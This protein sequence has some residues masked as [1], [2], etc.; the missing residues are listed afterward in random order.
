MDR[1]DLHRRLPTILQIQADAWNRGDIEAFMDDYWKS[2]QLTFSS[3]GE[4]QRGWDATLQR[5][6]RRYPTPERMGRLTFSEIETQSLG[7]AAALVL[8]RWR[9]ER[10]PDSI[11]GAFSLVFRL[12]DERWLIVHDHTS[13]LAGE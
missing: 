2:D 3:A 12:I 1:V 9:L 13:T 6:K 11:G 5:Y 7:R 10:E 8:G 4:T